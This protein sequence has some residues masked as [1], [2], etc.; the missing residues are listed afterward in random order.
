M[1]WPIP[2][3]EAYV[4][5]GERDS[6]QENRCV[7]ILQYRESQGETSCLFKKG[8][9]APVSRGTDIIGDKNNTDGSEP[10]PTKHVSATARTRDSTSVFSASFAHRLLLLAPWRRSQILGLRVI[11]L[12]SL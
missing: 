3:R 6:M 1:P 7:Y 9:V 2:V 5:A 11:I 8:S 4:S 10:H 12:F